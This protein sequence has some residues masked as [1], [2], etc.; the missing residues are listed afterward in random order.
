[1]ASPKIKVT[2][3]W[4]GEAFQPTHHLQLY[5]CADHQ[6]AN[7]NL[8]KVRGRAAVKLIQAWRLSRNTR[9]PTARKVGADALSSLCTLADRWCAEDREAGRMS[10][11]QYVQ[12]AAALEVRR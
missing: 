5:C 9:N 8:E 12:R 4:C 7:A 2:C 10:A 1:M 3:A 6:T 11:L